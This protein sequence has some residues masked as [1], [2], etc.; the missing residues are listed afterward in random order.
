MTSG[1]NCIS[2]Q[3]LRKLSDRASIETGYCFTKEGPFLSFNQRT[4]QI[5]KEPGALSSGAF[6]DYNDFSPN[7]TI[8]AMVTSSY[9]TNMGLFDRNL[10][11]L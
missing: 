1:N 2:R 9:G 11:N 6:S 3:N 7:H 4:F 5:D 10:S 8:T